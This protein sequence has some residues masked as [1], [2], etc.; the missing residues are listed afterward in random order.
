MATVVA[1]V[2]SIAWLCFCNLTLYCINENSVLKHVVKRKGRLLLCSNERIQPRPMQFFAWDI[3]DPNSAVTSVVPLLILSIYRI[4]TLLFFGF[5]ILFQGVWGSKFSSPLFDWLTYYTNWTFVGFGFT[6]L[7]SILI[8]MQYWRQQQ[9]KQENNERRT[10]WAFI[11]KVYVMTF[12]TVCSSSIFL[13]I[14]YWTVLYD[15]SN[16]KL[17]DA[18][19]HGINV[20]L[21][22]IDLL[23]SRIPI[24]SYH[25]QVSLLYGSLYVAFMWIYM[26]VS[27]HWIYSTLDWEK[28]TAVIYY[29]TIPFLLILSL[30]ITYGVACFREAV[31]VRTCKT[32]GYS[33]AVDNEYE[34]ELGKMKNAAET[35]EIL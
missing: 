30:F 32:K 6:A 21:L 5:G 17:D 24:I 26:A 33:R 11:H 15:G 35:A 18:M 3:L 31:I 12:V 10:Q 27:G 19:R 23:M 9:Q 7:L 20:L 1:P 2:L 13:S 22:L 8:M 25:F 4:F 14:F 34:I 29:V 16:V 28:N